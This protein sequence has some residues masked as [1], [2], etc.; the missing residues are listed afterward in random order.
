MIFESTVKLIL[1]LPMVTDIFIKI[2]PFWDGM[3]TKKAPL[4]WGFFTTSPSGIIHKLNKLAANL[5][6]PK[7]G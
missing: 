7:Q 6:T 4:P 2:P 3:I 1:I 5:L